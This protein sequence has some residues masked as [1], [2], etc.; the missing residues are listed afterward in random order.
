M[1]RLKISILGS[2]DGNKEKEFDGRLIGFVST[3]EAKA[4]KYI[5]DITKGRKLFTSSS[6]HFSK[7]QCNLNRRLV[8][9]TTNYSLDYKKEIIISP[10]IVAI[11]IK[12]EERRFYC[13]N[14]Q[15][16]T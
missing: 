3:E 4:L 10:E 16:Y 13:S 14:G 1:S 9:A 6:V 8:I 7:S 15:I 11:V 12:Q 5:D 2:I